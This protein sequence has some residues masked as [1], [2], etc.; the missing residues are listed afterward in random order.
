MATKKSKEVQK[1]S[2]EQIEE[3]RS[4]IDGAYDLVFNYLPQSAYQLKWKEEWLEKA[5]KYGASLDV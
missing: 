3:M 1:Y 4:L 5:R 2:E